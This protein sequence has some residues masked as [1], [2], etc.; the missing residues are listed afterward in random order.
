MVYLRSFLFNVIWLTWSSLMVVCVPINAVFHRGDDGR[1]V[2]RASRVW[3]RGTAA[4]LRVFC[5][6]TYRVEGLETM[7]DGPL[8]MACKH[9]SAFETFVMSLIVPDLC[10][11]YKKELDSIPLFGWFLRNSNMLSVDRLGGATALRAMLESAR[12]EAAKGRRLLIFPE[13]TRVAVGERGV[14]HPGLI[15]LVRA[16]KL[17]IVPV[18]L[19][20]GVYWPRRSWLRHPG[21]ITIR[22]LPELGDISAFTRADMVALVERISAE[23]DILTCTAP[24]R[25]EIERKG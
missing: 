17:P 4:L 25:G 1:F 13:G 14:A 11:I 19:N 12:G 8:I 2:R 7:P 3:S 5:G 10:I 21:T 23:S 9:Q 24:T 6:L 16:L 15:A 22:V 20:S 18:S